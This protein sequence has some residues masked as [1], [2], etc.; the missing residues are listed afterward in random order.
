MNMSWK[1]N[2][3][4]KIVSFKNFFEKTCFFIYVYIKLAKYYCIYCN[5]WYNNV[6]KIRN[7]GLY[8]IVRR[9]ID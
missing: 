8:I 6:I 3:L 4:V 9:P 2:V 7:E 5:V 1:C